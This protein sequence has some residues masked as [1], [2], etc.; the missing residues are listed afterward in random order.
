MISIRGI[1]QISN[2]TIAAFGLKFHAPK[3]VLDLLNNCTWIKFGY[4]GVVAITNNCRE[5]CAVFPSCP[6]FITDEDVK[7]M[8]SNNQDLEEIQLYGL[9]SQAS[10]TAIADNCPKLKKLTYDGKT[11]SSLSQSDFDHFRAKCPGVVLVL[12]GMT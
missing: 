5:L 1:N 9:L 11:F 3:K 4:G 8:V 12:R 6:K 2:Q 7:R 10:L